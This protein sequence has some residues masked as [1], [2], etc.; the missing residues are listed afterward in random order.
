MKTN[1]SQVK[2]KYSK[3]IWTILM[4]FLVHTQTRLEAQ[5]SNYKPHSEYYRD[6][7]MLFLNTAKEGKGIN[8][9]KFNKGLNMIRLCL[10]TPDTRSMFRSLADNYP[11]RA[12]GTLILFHL[13]YAIRY[14]QGFDSVLVYVNQMVDEY[15]R[16]QNPMLGD[17]KQ[18]MLS[19][20]QPPANELD[21]MIQVYTQ[22]LAHYLTKSDSDAVALCYWRISDVMSNKGLREKACYY[23]RKSLDF[24]NPNHTMDPKLARIWIYI[25]MD[26]YLNQTAII[27]QSYEDDGDYVTGLQYLNRA[28]NLAEK[29]SSNFW[30]SSLISYCSH[31]VAYSK[32]MLGQTDSV[33]EL[34]QRS[35]YIAEQNHENENMAL[36]MQVL[37][38]YYQVKNL[39]D[40]AERQF[41]RAIEFQK[42]IGNYN[43]TSMGVFNPRFHLAKI[44]MNQSKWAEAIKLLEEDCKNYGIDRLH[45]IACYKLLVQAYLQLGES[46]KARLVFA[47][48]NNLQ[49]LI[50]K[51]LLTNKSNVFETE[52]KVAEAENS[53]ILI[54]AE[55][56]K[57]KEARNYFIGIA[58]IFLLLAA[59]AYN[60]FVVSRKQKNLIEKEK[61]R[62]EELLLNILPAEVAQELKQNGNSQARDIKQ[63]TVMFTDFK[64]F[65]HIAQTFS[66]QD[67]VAEIHECFSEFDRI[68][69]KHG[70]EKIKTIGD[71][72]MAAGGIPTAN[73]SHAHDMVYAALEIQ[74][75]MANLKSRRM[76]EGKPFFEIRI[77]IHTGPVVA[78]IV[79]VKKFAYD[80]WGDT[81][82][83]ASRMESHGEVGKINI[84]KST[85]DLVFDRFSL[86]YR[87]K[88]QVKGKGE[89]EMYFVED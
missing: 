37:G 58:S 43:V 10:P 39:P 76:A 29:R 8:E 4:V 18:M 83:T 27:G 19:H 55:R 61:Q 73:E 40:S 87:G 51:D 85:R 34:L 5:E 68:M 41:Q 63:A 82:N 52:K 3:L 14:N 66:S 11:N 57:A 81:V 67:L 17:L 54:A 88:I 77:G 33:Y 42:S 13:H 78:G 80:I 72:Y 49:D 48:I 16:T 59:G 12:Y 15:E 20:L 23:L 2:K 64:D 38:I 79:G 62:S 6:S 35:L 36:A 69:G 22:Y 60:R 28:L 53:I 1:A 21:R 9:L 32:L 65:T 25:G 46:E 56:E 45:T 44:K 24:V 50:Q 86:N 70:L 71:S 31:H 30:D 74:K 84:S 47:E 26:L 75:F 89:I 7:A